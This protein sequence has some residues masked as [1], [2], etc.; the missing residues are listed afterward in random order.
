MPK[1]GFSSLDK[2][3]QKTKEW[4]HDVQ[5]ELGWEDEMRYI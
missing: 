3:M 1:S 5:D 2:S 4:L